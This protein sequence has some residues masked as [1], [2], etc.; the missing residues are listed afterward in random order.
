[1]GPV[2]GTAMTA[3][4]ATTAETA[5]TADDRVEW[6]FTTPRT[7]RSGEIASELFGA[8][9]MGLLAASN[10]AL[11][12]GLFVWAVISDEAEDGVPVFALGWLLVSAGMLAMCVVMG[13]PAWRQLRPPTDVV[14]FD[15]AGV[16]RFR[17]RFAGPRRGRR[18]LAWSQ[19]TYVRL[20]A[21]TESAVVTTRDGREHI[22]TDLGS[23]TERAALVAAL[24]A[25]PI[26]LD[27]PAS[28]YPTVRAELADAGPPDRGVGGPLTLAAVPRGWRARASAGD[29]V[30]MWRSTGRWR[31]W[32]LGVLAFFTTCSAIGHLTGAD[33]PLRPWSGLGL[34]AVAAAL[35]AW[36]VAEGRRTTRGW[37]LRTGRLAP[38]RVRT[39][40]GRVIED[41]RQ[42]ATALTSS[43][44]RRR[45]RLRY[46]LDAV[47]DDGRSVALYGGPRREP[48]DRFAAWLAHHAD[49]PLDD[50]RADV[51]LDDRSAGQQ[52]SSASTCAPQGGRST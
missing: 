17:R 39:R 42:R 37:L 46:R 10:L 44:Y 30:L 34:S 29:T 32:A 12:I 15:G 13:R 48:V 8:V 7:M 45:G 18:R 3:G 43:G 24:T 33:A 14:G 41:A 50:R 6:R 16:W 28:P 27:R 20:T 40:S 11:M 49:A 47:L 52:S 25:D 9:M 38:A 21:G 22:L 26:R 2:A 36:T 51:R 4:K 23:R 1:M 19:V 31:A 5:E 35:A